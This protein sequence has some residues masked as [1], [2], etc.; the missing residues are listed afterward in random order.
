MPAAADL[1]G[2]TK[3]DRPEWIE[4]RR[5]ERRGLRHAD[6][7]RLARD[8]RGARLNAANPRPENDYGHIVRWQED[9]P[10]AASTASSGTCSRWAAI[11]EVLIRTSG[12][13]SRAMSSARPDGLWFDARAAT[14]DPDRRVDLVLNKGDYARLGNNQMLVADSRAARSAAS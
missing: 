6:Q 13:T 10:D 12:A 4:V 7:Q 5:A 3:V 2:A 8:T 11:R 14:V 1:A 9:D